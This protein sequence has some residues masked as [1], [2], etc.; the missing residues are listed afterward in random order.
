[1]TGKKVRSLWSNGPGDS[2][3][4]SPRP[5][6]EFPTHT[7]G[8]NKTREDPDNVF[9]GVE[10]LA[11]DRAFSRLRSRASQPA[12]SQSRLTNRPKREGPLGSTQPDH[13]QTTGTF[14]SSIRFCFP[15]VDQS[16]LS[17]PCS[18]RNPLCCSP[19]SL[20]HTKPAQP[21]W[22]LDPRFPCAFFL[23]SEKHW[24]II[25]PGPL[26]QRRAGERSPQKKKRKPAFGTKPPPLSLSSSFFQPSRCTHL[27]PLSPTPLVME[28][29]RGR[30]KRPG[31]NPSR[32]EG[33]NEGWKGFMHTPVAAAEL[34]QTET[35]VRAFGNPSRR[36]QRIHTHV[37][38]SIHHTTTQDR[39][40]LSTDT[41]TNVT[42]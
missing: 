27:L 34:Q 14:D 38:P 37:R 4:L 39:R 36:I 9:L 30:G 32:G 16:L 8:T 40:V 18:W 29:N 20:Q 11:S 35:T 7:H 31:R 5:G 26:R 19:C 15:K 24:P 2:V 23:L 41:I 12:P 22:I 10:R 33:A 1:M 13:S 28:T 3:T 6:N 25:H 21:H 42:H 17:S